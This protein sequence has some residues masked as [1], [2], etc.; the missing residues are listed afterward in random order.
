MYSNDIQN[1]GFQEGRKELWKEAQFA[2]YLHSSFYN[3][4]EIPEGNT[5][6]ILT[7]A[8]CGW[9]EPGC[10]LYYFIDFSVFGIYHMK[11]KMFKIKI[12]VY[13]SI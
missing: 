8:E 4:K 10:L 5:K 9:S 3:I 11:I 1:F 2:W 7:S 13:F 6:K 12:A